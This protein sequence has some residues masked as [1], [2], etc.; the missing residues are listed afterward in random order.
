MLGSG[1][2][3]RNC[4]E[5]LGDQRAAGRGHCDDSH[6]CWQSRW[7]TIFSGA[8]HHWHCGNQPVAFRTFLNRSHQWILADFVRPCIWPAGRKPIKGHQF[9]THYWGNQS[10]STNSV[11]HPPPMVTSGPHTQMCWNTKHLPRD[12]SA[13]HATCNFIGRVL[14]PRRARHDF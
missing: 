12:K 11:F 3:G 9:E 7:R 1:A 2:R 14:R 4:D 5:R 13:R 6:S 8:I 10:E